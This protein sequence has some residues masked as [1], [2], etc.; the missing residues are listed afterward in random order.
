LRQQ[1]LN[2]PE[3][4]LLSAL[5]QFGLAGCEDLPVRALSQGQR[6]R[7]ALARLA[8]SRSRRLW[9]LDE[10][11]TALDIRAVDLIRGMIA[12]H[13]SQHGVVVLTSHQEVDFAGATMR[14]LRL[15]A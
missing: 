5:E 14:R 13:L 15:D 3:P 8:F 1:G 7:V 6:R 10:P 9:V 11:F 2:V 4:A 12:A